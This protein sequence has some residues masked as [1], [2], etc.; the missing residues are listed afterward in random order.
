ME[1]N[2]LKAL[3]VVLWGRGWQ[4]SLA[5]EIGVNNRTVRAWIAGNQKISEESASKIKQCAAMRLIRERC[6][7][8]TARAGTGKAIK[9]EPSAVNGWRWC[10]DRDICREIH[11][12]LTDNNI[13]STLYDW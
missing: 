4:S 11:K 13:K 12:I 6:I 8:Y 10:I 7:K 2:D 9:L 1:V 3:G 5:R